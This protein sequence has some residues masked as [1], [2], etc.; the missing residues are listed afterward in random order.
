MNHEPIRRV[1]QPR[2]LFFTSSWKLVVSW[3]TTRNR[4]S[5]ALQHQRSNP[6]TG[7]PAS[8]KLVTRNTRCKGSPNKK[9]PLKDTRRCLGFNSLTVG[10]ECWHSLPLTPD[11]THIVATAKRAHIRSTI[12]ARMLPVSWL[13]S[14][15][16]FTFLVFYSWPPTWGSRIIPRKLLQCAKRTRAQVAV[17]NKL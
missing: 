17:N 7:T 6:T 4:A 3:L 14:L 5:T 10:A 15:T 1:Y 12:D 13:H 11:A 16:K 9:H 2:H 8:G